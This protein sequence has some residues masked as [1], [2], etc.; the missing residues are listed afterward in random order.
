MD[1]SACGTMPRLPALSPR[2]VLD[3]LRERFAALRGTGGPVRLLVDDRP[4]DDRRHHLEGA[5]AGQ[6]RGVETENRMLAT[7]AIAGRHGSRRLVR[8]WMIASPATAE[9]VAAACK[10]AGAAMH[11]T[12]VAAGLV[13]ET[14]LPASAAWSAAM[15]ATSSGGAVRLVAKPHPM[16]DVEIVVPERGLP[17]SGPWA[18]FSAALAGAEFTPDR[19]FV[20]EDVVEASIVLVDRLVE[21][22]VATAT[23]P[24][25]APPAEPAAGA[26]KAAPRR[27]KPRQSVDVD[28]LLVRLAKNVGKKCRDGN[29]D[30]FLEAE[31]YSKGSADLAEMLLENLGVEV[32][33]QTIRR[34]VGGAHASKLYAEWS[35][36]RTTAGG[37]ARDQEDDLPRNSAPMSD[38]DAQVD[39]MLRSGVVTKRNRLRA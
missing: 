2:R 21:G 39:E 18:E 25:A 20:V 36:L 17:A 5:I 19:L 22:L 23:A 16:G 35:R 13:G 31:V 29:L 10:A 9:A 3:N 12:L 30:A 27:G 34:K 1:G 6:I 15:A 38:Q 4:E 33:P 37:E 32:S 14:L 7:V 24:P 11:P 28:A 8:A 26:S